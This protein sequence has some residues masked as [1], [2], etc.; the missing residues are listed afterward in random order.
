MK[1]RA[2]NRAFGKERD[3]PEKNS[4]GAWLLVRPFS[5]W[6]GLTLYGAEEG[7]YLT[8]WS[9]AAISMT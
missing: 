8:Y 6:L 3:Q 4:T 1:G 2:E 9:L 5:T 7:V